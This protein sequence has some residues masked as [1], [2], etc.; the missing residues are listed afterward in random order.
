MIR[1]NLLV[2]LLSFNRTGIIYGKTENDKLKVKYYV[3][4][5]IFG[6]IFEYNIIR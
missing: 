1:K 2:K 3:T 6:T 5:S 4:K